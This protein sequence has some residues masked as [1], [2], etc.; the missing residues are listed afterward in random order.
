M[1]DNPLFNPVTLG[2]LPLRHRIVMAP[3]TRIRADR[4]TLAPTTDNTTYYGQRA[5][6][7]GL[8][9]TEA[10]HISP[11]GTPIWTI[12]QNVRD[13]GGQVPGIWTDTQR[14]GWREVVNA[15]HA[16]KGLIVCQLLHAGRIAQPEIGDHPVAANSDLPLPSVSASAIA[17]PQGDED[18]HY[19]W[20]QPNTPPRA[21]ATAEMH[22]IC[23]DY[24]HAAHMAKDA[25]FD[26]IELHAAH[27]YLIDQFLNKST[28]QRDDMYGGSLEN[29]CRLLFEV[30]TTLIDVMGKGRVGVR[31]SPYLNDPETGA[32]NATYFGVQSDD[33]EAVYSHAV[34]GLN[35]FDLAYLLLT[36]PRVG[37]M[38]SDPASDQGFRHP[39]SLRHYRTLYNG[40]LMGAGGFTPL[41]AATAITQNAYDLIAFGRWFIS[42]PDLPDRIRHGHDLTVYDRATFYSGSTAGYTDYPDS[43]DTAKAAGYRMIAV[44][45]VGASLPKTG[46]TPEKFK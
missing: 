29:R 14:D 6:E 36:E 11:E 46:Q 44:A 31:L 2:A 5:S 33:A 43:Y 16:R 8:I 7:G 41:T 26:A 21:L 32:P 19:G 30:I 20:D 4:D 39:L 1:T 25:G 35:D 15:V 17:L 22:R 10:V 12:Y 40:M 28:N 34:R 27:G 13:D 37:G 3:M 38:A 18:S 9:I 45:D 42:N 23:A 24:A